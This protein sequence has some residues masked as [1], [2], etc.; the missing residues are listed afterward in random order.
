M[1]SRIRLSL[2]I[3]VAVFVL[4]LVDSLLRAP[5]TS[6]GVPIPGYMWFRVVGGGFIA[7]LCFLGC[8]LGFRIGNAQRLSWVTGAVIV[9]LYALILVLPSFP[10]TATIDHSGNI[11]RSSG[12]WWSLAAPFVLPFVL[13][14]VVP[15][16]P[17]GRR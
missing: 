9:V 1:L 7:A 16:L 10:V 3:C 6:N 12:A 4:A 14:L 15:K 8:Y 5:D 11:Q 17:L 13:A 2:V